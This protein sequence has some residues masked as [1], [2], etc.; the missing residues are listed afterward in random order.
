MEVL[1]FQQVIRNCLVQIDQAI[2]RIALSIMRFHSTGQKGRFLD[3]ACGFARNDQCLLPGP[4]TSSGAG[5]PPVPGLEGLPVVIRPFVRLQGEAGFLAVEEHLEEEGALLGAIEDELEV[6]A[7]AAGEPE[8]K[9]N[10]CK[11]E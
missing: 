4:S 5:L 2:S 10:P 9:M 7:D 1:A 8:A 6:G 3:S 11:S